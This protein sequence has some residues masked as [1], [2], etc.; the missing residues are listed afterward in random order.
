MAESGKVYHPKCAPSKRGEFFPF[1]FFLFRK[2]EK[3]HE[4]QRLI[5][6]RQRASRRYQD[7]FRLTA[8]KNTRRDPKRSGLSKSRAIKTDAVMA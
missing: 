5:L 3:K 7:K 4:K 6:M 8:C 1:S 2:H